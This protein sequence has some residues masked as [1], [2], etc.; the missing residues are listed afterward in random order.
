MPNNVR[1]ILWER[2]AISQPRITACLDPQLLKTDP[3]HNVDWRRSSIECAVT[4]A[5]ARARFFAPRPSAHSASKPRP[6]PSGAIHR[7]GPG[8]ST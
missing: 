4:I 6:W 2:P 1:Q 8:R 7:P 3:L 5:T